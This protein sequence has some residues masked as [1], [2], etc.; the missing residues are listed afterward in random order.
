MS[1]H[2]NGAS[3]GLDGNLARNALANIFRFG[4]GGI[5]GTLIHR[6]LSVSWMSVDDTRRPVRALCK[7]TSSETIGNR[8]DRTGILLPTSPAISLARFARFARLF[9]RRSSGF[10]NIIA[11][12]ENVETTAWV[13]S[14]NRSCAMTLVAHTLKLPRRANDRWNFAPAQR[15]GLG[16]GRSCNSRVKEGTKCLIRISV[17]Q[18]ARIESDR[19]YYF[20]VVNSS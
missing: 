13:S 19:L 14:L 15:S 10:I 11:H 2:E 4:C 18:P 5:C 20:H 7:H 3:R 9:D 1:L 12:D 8:S 6:T 17:R 16:G